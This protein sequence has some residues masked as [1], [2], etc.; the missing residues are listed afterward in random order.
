[1]LVDFENIEEGSYDSYY[2]EDMVLDESNRIHALV[3]AIIDVPGENYDSTVTTHF[4][5]LSF[6]LEGNLLNEHLF[7]LESWPD[8]PREIACSGQLSL[9]HKW[10]DH[11]ENQLVR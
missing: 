3:D 4:C 8:R 9:C 5:I 11:L 7:P 10:F 2:P 1:M 6:D